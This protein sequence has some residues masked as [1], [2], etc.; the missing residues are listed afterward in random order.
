MCVREKSFSFLRK[1]IYAVLYSLTKYIAENPDSFSELTFFIGP[2]TI[3]LISNV[4]FFVLT[5]IHCNKVK[6]EIKRV[7]TDPMDPRSKRFHSDRTR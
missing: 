2:I 5:S 7:T 4:V 1:K 6:A 3:Q